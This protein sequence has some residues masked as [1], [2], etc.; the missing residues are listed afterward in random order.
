MNT[1]APS[2]TKPISHF[3]LVSGKRV[4]GH[5]LK[6]DA[7]NK[8][9]SSAGAGAGYR[10]PAIYYEITPK[11]RGELEKQM[12][13]RDEAVQK[14]E[15]EAKEIRDAEGRAQVLA[16]V[17]VPQASGCE[18]KLEAMEIQLRRMAKKGD[19][20]MR[21]IQKE[22]Q[23]MTL[24]QKEVAKNVDKLATDMMILES[25]MESMEVKRE[26]DMEIEKE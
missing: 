9:L 25:K 19:R 13:E 1:P 4:C 3:H 23:I 8:T 17:M 10:Y 14:A 15:R 18:T 16:D 26:E 24:K 2:P 7:L 22:M 6:L 11:E 21:R 12:K 20:S 5:N